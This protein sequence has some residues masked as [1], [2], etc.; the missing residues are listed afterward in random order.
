[1][2]DYLIPL[3]ASFLPMFDYILW[4]VLGGF[5]FSSI[6]GFLRRFSSLR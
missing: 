1:M 2:I 6:P 3:V 5:I 4:I